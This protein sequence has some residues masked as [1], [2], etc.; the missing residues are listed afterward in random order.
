M[1][2]SQFPIPNSPNS[3]LNSQFSILNSQTT[4]LFEIEDTGF[5][6]ASEELASLFEAFSQSKAGKEIQEGTG[7]G[8]PIAKKFVQLMGG[9]I[10]IS[11]EVECGSLFKFDIVVG[12]VDTN[13]IETRQLTRRVIALEP[14]QPCYR[15]LVVDDKWDNRQLLIKLLNPLGFEMKEASNGMEAIEIWEGWQPHLIWM[16]MRMP[17]MDGYEATK[18]IK[19]HL[20]GQATA[21]I[22]LTASAWEEER[23][24]VLSAGCDD[25]VRKPF[26]EQE[27]FD[28]MAQYL[29]VRYLFE[30]LAPTSQEERLPGI[31]QQD[32]I[33][34]AQKDLSSP[35]VVS[36][37][38]AK[39]PEPWLSE[40][41]Q[42]A[43]AID[44]ERIFQL[45]EEIPPTQEHLAIAITDFVNNF[46]CDRIIDL[47]EETS[48][49]GIEN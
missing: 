36:S 4:I 45:L 37:A 43:D 16:D 46:R 10:S 12:V 30:E 21:I 3:I 38:L 14:N 49:L 2:N 6:I 15:I 23:A 32:K 22:A 42:A 24:V 28:K 27:L 18:H 19:T 34:V 48:S 7:L 29:G 47:I 8:L 13:D 26:Q 39:M 35:S 33:R 31:A 40:L 9:D 1:P 11:S 17:V 20:K 44:N 5:G 41:Y 25:F